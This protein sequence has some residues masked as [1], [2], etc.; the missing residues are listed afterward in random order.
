MRNRRQ[1]RYRHRSN[2]RNHRMNGGEQKNLMSPS[3]PFNGRQRGNFVSHQNA[4]KLVERY[5]SLAKD[6]LSLGDKILSENYLQHADHFNRIL[7]NKNNIAS[8]KENNK[9]ETPEET[10]ID[11]EDISKQESN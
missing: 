3:I 4:E 11:K 6:A 7:E 9:I 5:T 10:K 1:R 8:Q 2:G